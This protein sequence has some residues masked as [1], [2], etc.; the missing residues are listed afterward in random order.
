MIPDTS[1]RHFS[2]SR[3]TPARFKKDL[4]K[5]ISANGTVEVDQLNHFLINIGHSDKLVSD[6]EFT[7]LLQ[8][9][10]A[11]APSRCIKAADMLRLV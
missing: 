7:T 1:L 9:A 10:G 6:D 2:Y 4:V 8:E 5:A 3:E 11:T